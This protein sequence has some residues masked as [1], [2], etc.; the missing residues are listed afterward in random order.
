MKPSDSGAKSRAEAARIV[1]DVIHHGRSLDQVFSLSSFDDRDQ[2]LIRALAYGTL[3]TYLRN[4]CLIDQLLAKPLKK[5]DSIIYAL[6]SVGLFALTDS[7]RP[8]YAVVSA[9]VSAADSLGRK[10]M[11][12]MVNAVL[13]RFLRERD[14]LL[15][16]ITT[17]AEA[18]TLHPQW[19]VE[20]F[21]ADWPKDW[22]HIVA[23]GNHQ[24]PMWVRVNESRVVPQEWLKR[25][26]AVG[27][28]TQSPVADMPGAVLLEEPCAVSELPGFSDGD[29][30]VQDIASQLPAYYLQAES[31]MRVLDACAAPGGKTGHLLEKYPG[32]EL[33]AVDSASE[34]LERVE[35]N[36]ERLGLQAA[37]VC[38][39]A[40][41]PELWWDGE[42]F[43]RILLDA[44]CSATGVIRRHPDIRFLRRASDIATM[45]ATQY[46]LLNKLWSLLKPGGFMLYTT[47]SVLSEEN[48][49]VV[50]R[51]LAARSDAEEQAL[52]TL[53][54]VTGS[55]V[56]VGLQ[57]LPDAFG[58]DGFYYAL[59]KR[60]V[61]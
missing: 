59:L 39:D 2:A 27:I 61:D 18:Q 44:P 9:T 37:V 13:R 19:L 31:G 32:I 4:K 57:L 16:K 48:A 29:C 54:P 24:A 10:H 25:A 47:C 46:E 34:R 36:L 49:E 40:R 6:L 56:P 21:Q 58:N 14:E 22:Q 35:E 12:G 43:D 55:N 15:Q 51:F 26:A 38:G 28:S 60:S 33:S 52:P 42:L 3:R 7:K 20:K 11:R 53:A 5:K 8:D 41:A 45:A 1:N 23:A 50:Q 17:V 30:S